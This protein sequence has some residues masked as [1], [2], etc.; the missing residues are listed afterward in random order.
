MIID[1]L[2]SINYKSIYDDWKRENQ[3]NLNTENSA[4]NAASKICKKYEVPR[5]KD[6]KAVERGNTAK[7]IYKIM[8]S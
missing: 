4:F 3:N 2:K 1:E 6:K 7:Q 8:T 5:E